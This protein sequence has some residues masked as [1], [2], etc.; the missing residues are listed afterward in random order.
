MT[1]G[2]MLDRMTSAE[3]I[4]WMALMKIEASERKQAQDMAAQRS[5][6]KR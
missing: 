2:E 4:E 5:R 3:L 1:V 6:R